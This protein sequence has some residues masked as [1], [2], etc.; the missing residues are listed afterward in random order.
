MKN[1]KF[2]INIATVDNAKL[3]ISNGNSKTGNIPYFSTNPGA[4]FMM[5]T[6]E[7]SKHYGEFVGNM[8]GTCAGVCDGCEGC[9]YAVRDYKKNMTTA[10]KAW[11][12]NTY[13]AMREPARLKAEL[14]NWL[15]INEPRY[16]RIHESGEFFSYNYF[17]MW[18]EIAQNNPFTIFYTYTKHSEFIERYERETGPLPVNLVILVSIWHDTVKNYTD[19][20]EFIYD[21]GTEEY[22]KY[23]DHCPA[24]DANGHKTG[25]TCR[26]CKKCMRAKKGDKIAVYAH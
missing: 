8:P 9:C 10:G 18:V 23:I 15:E 25:I 24:V 22:V 3:Y 4:G 16:F 2:F 6:G 13:L 17:L 26:Q 11:N 14:L 5:I 1:T 19:A 7:K 21:D 20:P 12:S